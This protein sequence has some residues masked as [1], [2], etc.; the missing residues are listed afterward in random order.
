[1]ESEEAPPTIEQEQDVVA[2]PTRDVGT[3]WSRLDQVLELNLES[4]RMRERVEE[5]LEEFPA[6]S[7][8]RQ[9]QASFLF[10]PERVTLSSNDDTTPSLTAPTQDN[11]YNGKAQLETFSSFKLRLQ[12]M[13]RGVRSI[14][15]LSSSIP[16]A[17]IQIPNNELIFFY[18]RIQSLAASTPIIYNPASVYQK[19]ETVYT[20]V[21]VNHWYASKQNGNINHPVTDPNW[22]VDCG[23]DGTRPNYFQ[24]TTYDAEDTPTNMEYV[25]ISPSTY[26]PEELGPADYDLLNRTFADYQDL[27]T[28]LE[29][30]AAHPTNASI[31][32]DVNFV[33]VPELNK[34]QFAGQDIFNAA[35]NP[36]GYYYIPCGYEDP[37]IADFYASIGPGILPDFKPNYTL[38]SRLGFTWNGLLVDPFSTNPY[39]GWNN[40]AGTLFLYMRPAD[41]SPTFF[42]WN[43]QVT[44]ANSYPNLVYSTVCRIF[45]DFVLGST[46]DSLSQGGLLGTVPMNATTLGIAFNQSTFNNPLTKIPENITEIEIRLE[47]DSGDPFYLPNSAV[48]SLEL[49]ITYK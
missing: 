30:C 26:F 41:P 31:Q 27:A 40:F 2:E 10:Q 46:Q 33:Y 23:T 32:N 36:N 5:L 15:L 14:Q 16:N 20:T 1:M 22:W 47:T 38:N 37:N 43:E 44:T 6:Q 12:K 35:T 42:A 39:N 29:A 21:P 49:A 25:Y 34:I 8:L 17:L 18:Y 3:F 13:L 28:T 19:G 24:L 11:I 7:I 4:A 9:S 48:V 45:A